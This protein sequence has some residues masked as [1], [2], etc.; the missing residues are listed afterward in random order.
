MNHPNHGQMLPANSLRDYALR[1]FT[2]VHGRGLAPAFTVMHISKPEPG[3]SGRDLLQL[4]FKHKWL[5]LVAIAVVL[6][7][8][9]FVT[10]QQPTYYKAK[11]R[12]VIMTDQQRGASSFLAGITTSS[13][14][15]RLDPPNRQIETEMSA[16]LSESNVEAIVQKYNLTAAMLKRSPLEVVYASFKPYVD[17]LQERFPA[18]ATRRAAGMSEEAANA[19]DAFFD[20]TT[21][22]AMRSKSS[23]VTSNVIEVTLTGTDPEVVR[24][25]LGSLVQLYVSRASARDLQLV[26]QAVAVL[27]EQTADAAAKLAEA[28][29]AVIKYSL[30]P[31]VSANGATLAARTVD[32]IND[33]LRADIEALQ[34]K[35][36]VLRQTYGEEYTEVRTTRAALEQL[37]ARQLTQSQDSSRRDVTIGILERSRALAETRYSDLRRN[38]DQVELFMA[39]APT[40]VEGRIAVELPRSAEK[41]SVGPKIA[42]LSLGPLV[43]VVLALALAVAFDL[44]DPRL[45][46]G[47]AVARYLG[48]EALGSVPEMNARRTP[49]TRGSA[50]S[51]FVPIEAAAHSVNEENEALSSLS[52]V[53]KQV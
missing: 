41:L 43:G 24:Q 31:A 36:D 45:Q 25:A 34:A 6:S 14:Q 32:S 8:T 39:L 26:K 16:L 4:V 38:L 47:Y 44:M 29:D 1:D 30:R 7:L 23:D 11:A 10:L 37:R 48:L 40:E 15:I 13:D 22:E 50:P 20:S 35:L 42:M 51:Y 5:V 21:T 53:S 46:S 12:V 52:S 9:I 49:S 3:F 27:S 28:D 18:L 2:E 17:A 19:I 33:K